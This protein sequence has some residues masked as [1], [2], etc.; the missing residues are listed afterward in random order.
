MKLSDVKIDYNYHRN[1]IKFFQNKIKSIDEE[2]DK[3]NLIRKEVKEFININF[4]D[5]NSLH[6]LNLSP[7]S[8][9]ALSVMKINTISELCNLSEE[10]LRKCR[11]IGDYTITNICLALREKGLK[12]KE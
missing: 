10:E 1:D 6:T 9:L 3:L 4:K 8:I 7:R 5:E 2:I 12:L 11:N